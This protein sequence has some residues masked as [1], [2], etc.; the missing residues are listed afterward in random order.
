MKKAVFYIVFSLAPARRK[1][2]KITDTPLTRPDVSH[3]VAAEWQ[4]G[5]YARAVPLKT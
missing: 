4:K 2:V 3:V 5:H 1:W